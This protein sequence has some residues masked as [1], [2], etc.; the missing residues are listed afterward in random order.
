MEM[1]I[2]DFCCKTSDFIA[3]KFTTTYTLRID[4]FPEPKIYSHYFRTNVSHLD[5]EYPNNQKLVRKT[6]N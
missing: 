3:T 2:E 1:V 6:R 4:W 5:V